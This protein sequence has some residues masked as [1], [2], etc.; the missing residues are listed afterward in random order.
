MRHSSLSWT[1]SKLHSHNRQMWKP[2][3]KMLVFVCVCVGVCVIAGSSCYLTMSSSTSFIN[4]ALEHCPRLCLGVRRKLTQT[5][6]NDLHHSGHKLFCLPCRQY[7]N[8]HSAPRTPSSLISPSDGSAA[9]L[10]ARQCNT[11]H[12]HKTQLMFPMQTVRII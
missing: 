5:F 3:N 9:R 6:T 4:R 8:I 2:L 10:F 7:H 1:T 12:S 11:A